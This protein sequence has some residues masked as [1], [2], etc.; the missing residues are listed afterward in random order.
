MEGGSV[1]TMEEAL[2]S[3]PSSAHT[4]NMIVAVKGFHEQKVGGIKGLVGDSG[5][6]QR[7][8]KGWRWSWKD[9]HVSGQ[10]LPRN[11]VLTCGRRMLSISPDWAQASHTQVDV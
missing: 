9:I 7:E 8:N 4:T 11:A 10:A 6:D 3:A 5:Q 2:Y 1:K